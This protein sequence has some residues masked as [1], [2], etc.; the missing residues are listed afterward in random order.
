MAGPRY[1]II[2]APSVLGLFP[3]GVEI[4]SET[5][6]AAGL[7]ERIGASR[8]GRAQPPPYDPQRDQATGLLNP[9]GIVDYSRALADTIMPLRDRGDVPL[10][11]GGDCSILLGCL[12][13][14]RR[15]GRAGLLFLDGHADFYQ[16]EAE[17]NGEAAS[18]E[19]ALATGRGPD[20]VTSI[21]G[22]RP[23]V[24]DQDVVV[25]GRRDADIADEYGSQRVEDTDIA[26]IDLAA[27]RQLGAP[28]AAEQ[29]LDR[30]R[31][32]EL[33]GFWIHLDADVLDDAVMPAV[34][35][36]MPGGLRWDELSTVLRQAIGSDRVLGIDITVFN[37]RLD[38]TGTIARS[39]VDALAKGLA[40]EGG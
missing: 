34:D 25:L 24:R 27:F 14:T 37:P 10:V 8:A 6:L 21:E 2:E 7:A 38:A 20:M 9:H 26:M 39:F 4:L 22:L 17:P 40:G 18:M 31:G 33:D 36:R 11:L 12:L 13:A 19:L 28:A 29:A 32:R 35:Y 30:L 1:A 16:P 23:L 5:L 15:R 3:G